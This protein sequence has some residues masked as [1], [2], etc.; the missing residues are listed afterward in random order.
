MKSGE[1]FVYFH[2]IV[3]SV[4]KIFLSLQII[5]FATKVVIVILLKCY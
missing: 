5:K 4:Y 1:K 2:S 3:F